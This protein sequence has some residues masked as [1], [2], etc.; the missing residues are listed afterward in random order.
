MAEPLDLLDVVVAAS[1]APRITAAP[2][3]PASKLFD[4]D[5]ASVRSSGVISQVSGVRSQA[6][7]VYGRLA[8]GH[9]AVDDISVADTRSIG[10]GCTDLSDGASSLVHD[11][12][13]GPRRES[14]KLP[15]H[16]CV[17]CGIH[18]TGSVVKCTSTGKWFCNARSSGSGSHIVQHL[19][20]GKFKEVSLHPESSLGDAVLE[21]YN[22]SSRNVFLLGFIPSTADAVVVLLCREPCLNIGALKDQGWDLSHWQPLIEDRAFLPWLVKVGRALQGFMH[23]PT[24]TP[25]DHFMRCTSSMIHHFPQV[26]GEKEVMRSRP[27]TS[28]QIAALESL[29]RTK[30]SATLDDLDKP[31]E[32]GGI[33]VE[34]VLLRYDD[35]YAYQNVFAPLVKLEADEDRITKESW[36]QDGVSVRWDTALN[37]RR[38]ARFR[39]AR[40]DSE[41]RLIAG[42]EMRLKLPSF[43]QQFG[44]SALI[45]AATSDGKTAGVATAVGSSPSDEEFAW[46]GTGVVRSVEDGE[47]TLEM[48]GTGSDKSVPTATTGYVVELVWHS[49][50]FDRMQAAL[51]RFALEEQS[52]SGFLYH[53]LL[54]HPVDPAQTLKV[55]VPA[56]ENCHAPGL[57]RLNPSQAAAVRAVLARPLSLIQGPP[58]TVS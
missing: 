14:Q 15:D 45:A 35:G 54:G 52:V 42:E 55:P 23:P 29:W 50:T 41:V 44:L 6:D 28:A 20:R 12:E 16:A 27:I 38:L 58:G 34:P 7:T 19:V 33:H 49:V 5:A 2:T 8:A 21:C 22:C 46:V 18:S 56:V 40:P 32:D 37:K 36:K 11:E 57:P 24:H 43:A 13:D 51:R 17:Y 39:F 48:S 9:R 3:A 10:D 26:P 4:D 53:A 25:S 31:D 1:S 30:P 47:I